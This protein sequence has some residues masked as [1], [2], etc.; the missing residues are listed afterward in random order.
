MTLKEGAGRY[1][2]KFIE[3]GCALDSL[4]TRSLEQDSLISYA[5]KKVAVVRDQDE[6]EVHQGTCGKPLSG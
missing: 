5:A 3:I 6:N 2:T 4:T 1:P